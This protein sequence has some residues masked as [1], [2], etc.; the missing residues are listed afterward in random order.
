MDTSQDIIK[1]FI[2][3]KCF[4]IFL[5]ER[6]TICVA[7]INTLWLDIGQLYH[8]DGYRAIESES[9]ADTSEME[10]WTDWVLVYSNTG[11]YLTLTLLVPY[12]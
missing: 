11:S 6:K 8:G 5:K 12:Y 2:S 1:M 7:K 9:F 3:I 4:S 10:N